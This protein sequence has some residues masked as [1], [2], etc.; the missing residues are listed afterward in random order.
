M[1]K[2]YR[3]VDVTVRLKIETAE[4]SIVSPI[5]LN[6]DLVRHAAREAIEREVHNGTLNGFTHDFDGQIVINVLG[7]TAI[8]SPSESTL[9]FTDVQK[10]CGGCPTVYEFKVQQDD[11][12]PV[13]TGYARYRHGYLRVVIYAASPGKSD[14][15]IITGKQLGNEWAGI[16]EWE[17]IEETVQ[18]VVGTHGGLETLIRK[19]I[20]ENYKDHIE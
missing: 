14:G 12:S 9:V 17:Q 7:V 6:D 20:A 11:A 16:I 4:D 2:N 10:T 18:A 13:R 5:D 15:Y 19:V 1:A 3:Y 8:D